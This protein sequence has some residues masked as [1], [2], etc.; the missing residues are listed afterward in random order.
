[1]TF[2]LDDFSPEQVRSARGPDMQPST[3][4]QGLAAATSQAMRDGNA[5]LQRQREVIAER[6]DLARL[7]AER[8]GTDGMR[9]II[10]GYNS[11]AADAGLTARQ[12]DAGI[13]VSEQAQKLGPNGAASILEAAR[14]AAG[15]DPEAWKDLDLS[16]E[17]IEA[18]VTAR[19]VQEDQEESQIL[20]MMPGGRGAAELAGGVVGAVADVRQWPF[21]LLGGGGGSVLKVMGREAIWGGVGSAATL[22]S[23]YEVAEEL[24][25]AA[26]NPVE[27][28]AFG[29]IGGAVLGG[30]IEGLGRAY[31][32]WRGRGEVREALPGLDEIDSDHII[33]TAEDAIAAGADPLAAVQRVIDGDEVTF[34]TDYDLDEI[35]GAAEEVVPPRAQL[36]QAFTAPSSATAIP[37]TPGLPRLDVS[38]PTQRIARYS[39][40][41]DIDP[42][43][44]GQLEGLIRE[45]DAARADLEAATGQ[46]TTDVDETLAAMATRRQELLD[47]HQTARKREKPRLMNAIREVESDR[48]LLLEARGETTE[49]MS[50]ARRRIIAA[51]EAMRDLGPRLSS[52]Y[53]R[54]PSE[55]GNIAQAWRNFARPEAAQA[56]WTPTFATRRGS[57]RA[58]PVLRRSQEEEA[59]DAAWD[60]MMRSSRTEGEGPFGPVFADVPKGVKPAIDR[61][62]KE[63]TGEVSGVVNREGIGKISLVYGNKKMGLAHIADKHPEMIPRLPEILRDGEIM[64][65]PNGLSRAYIIRRGDPAEVA[66]IRLDWDGRE[67]AWVV[68]SFRDDWGKFAR[69][70]R[71]AYRTDLTDARVP[72]SS[73]QGRNSAD[74]DSVQGRQPVPAMTDPASPEARALHDQIEGDLR[75]RIE[76]FGDFTVRTEEGD[77]PRMQSVTA[78]LDDLQKAEAFNDVLDACALP[79]RPR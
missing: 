33:T 72:A 29:A 60:A 30:G 2:M 37:T 6:D 62:L 3:F 61:L 31:R 69:D 59:L 55:A 1:M 23:E 49:G 64:Q 27:S 12:I 42:E 63:K 8:L 58:A 34:T 17:G 41:R 38:E 20:E 43:V 21:L 78:I 76:R 26:P 24:G 5:N 51:D 67:K 22:P 32:Y 16:D 57:D 73:G 28:V 10:E 45:R 71:E 15:T 75:D 53:A 4:G 52:A 19:R 25:K 39:A 9:P 14:V 13:P 7:A 40:A 70:P 74:G 36:E 46:R 48:R 50:E 66:T 65:D 68:T 44:F 11:R 35:F 18:R 54:V 79:G 77:K 56:G 47:A